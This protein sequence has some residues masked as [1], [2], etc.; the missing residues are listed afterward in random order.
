LKEVAL[1][2]AEDTRH[3]K[4]LL[5][6]FDIHTPLA[7]FHEHNEIKSLDKFIARL[8]E[9]KNIALVSDAGTPAI[10]DP[11][12]RLVR[13]AIE[14]GIKVEVIPGASA[15]ISALAVSGLPTDQ[16]TFVGFLPDKEGKRRNKLEGL[17]DYPHTLVFYVSKWKAEGVL[18]DMLT[19]FGDRNA[20]L[21]RE[22][23]KLHEEI[24]RAPLLELLKSVAGREVKG[25]LTLV[26]E[27]KRDG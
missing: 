20:V 18:T 27:G 10:S 21:C 19:V 1:I 22:M 15:A 5:T 26:V 3:T 8:S 4:K 17:K 2:A 14:A 16:F 11:G 13:A 9:G 23:T 12:F 24:T 6:H 7:A 25:E